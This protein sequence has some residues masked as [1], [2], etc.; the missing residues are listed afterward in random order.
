MSDADVLRWRIAVMIGDTT[1]R[2]GMAR[3]GRDDRDLAIRLGAI[4]LRA[5]WSPPGPLRC[6]ATTG[7]DPHRQED[8]LHD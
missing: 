5:I 1:L 4:I 8:R 3:N 6:W 7:S 2:H